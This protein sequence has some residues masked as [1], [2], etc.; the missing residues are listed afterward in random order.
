MKFSG[1]TVKRPQRKLHVLAG[2]ILH[3]VLLGLFL[4]IDATRATA[5]SC[6]EGGVCAL[7]DIGPGGG[8]VFYAPVT[9]FT[10]D[11]PCGSNCKYLEMAPKNWNG[12]S[13]DP[14]LRLGDRFV[15]NVNTR[16]NTAIGLGFRNTVGTV[17]CPLWNTWPPPQYAGCPLNTMTSS[18]W[19][20]KSKALYTLKD[21]ALH[22]VK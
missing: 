14:G 8:I 10:S 20:V 7:G 2:L 16:G 3:S 22:M 12:G 1:F 21:F 11:A 17:R 18:S 5:P 9:P 19:S 15:G 4:P 13:S 6:A